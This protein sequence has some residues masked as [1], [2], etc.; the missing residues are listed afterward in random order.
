VLSFIVPAHNEEQLLGRT[1][2]AIHVAARAPG[3]P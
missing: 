3:E 1:L 2:A